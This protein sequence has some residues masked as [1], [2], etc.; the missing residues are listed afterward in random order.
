[1]NALTTHILDTSLGV[2]AAGVTI[3]LYKL[4]SDKLTLI[5]EAVT[6]QDGRTDQPLLGD[7]QL[8]T[9]QYQ[10]MFEMGN[11]FLKHHTSLPDPLF[12]SDIPINFGIADTQSHYHVPLLVSPFG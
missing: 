10:L 4:E 9:G 1:M 5:T 6:N 2:P 11:Y 12:L 7:R 3:K 8:E